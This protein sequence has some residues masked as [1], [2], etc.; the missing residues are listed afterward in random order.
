MPRQATALHGAWHARHYRT[1]CRVTKGATPLAHTP[2]HTAGPGPARRRAQHSPHITEITEV[3]RKGREDSP[4]PTESPGT[5][6]GSGLSFLALNTSLASPHV[7][8]V[9]EV[10]WVLGAGREA[11]MACRVAVRPT[12]AGE[13][14]A[15][16]KGPE[17][18]GAQALTKNGGKC[19]GPQPTGR[20]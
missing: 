7:L 18:P 14:P 16:I 11:G 15:G 17:H 3:G 4:H 6:P 1:P 5:G 2:V 8:S 20:H 19:S 13:P 9:Q 12:P 10:C